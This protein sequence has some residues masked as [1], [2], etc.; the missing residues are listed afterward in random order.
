M[1][2][3]DGIIVNSVWSM[4]GEPERHA[5]PK[6]GPGMHSKSDFGV[7]TYSDANYSCRPPDFLPRLAS[8]AH[9]GGALQGNLTYYATALCFTT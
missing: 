7:L 3:A 8:S 9:L 1:G 2:S 6:V 5:S 4:H